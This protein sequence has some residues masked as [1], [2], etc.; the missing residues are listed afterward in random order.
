MKITMLA[1]ALVIL[2]AGL[3]VASEEA[4]DDGGLD[5]GLAV[6]LGEGMIFTNGQVYR[7]PVTVEVVPS[8]G[9]T[10][11]K[12]DLGL[13]TALENLRIPGSNIGRWH[14]GFRPGARLTPPFIP[15]YARLAFPL[16]IQE[17]DFDA[18]VMVGLGVDIRILSFLGIVFEVDTT[19]SDRLQFGGNGL[20]LEFRLGIALF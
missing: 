19:L 8:L 12:F 10:W 1:M 18:G 2:P 4:D 13:H 11:F 14:F 7:G 5:F 6:T 17:N 20:P 16:E 3:A 15:L 9:W